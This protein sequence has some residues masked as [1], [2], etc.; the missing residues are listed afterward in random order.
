MRGLVS[1]AGRVAA[2]L[3]AAL[4]AMA[5]LAVVPSAA[6]QSGGLDVELPPNTDCRGAAVITKATVVEDA[7]AANMLAE[8]LSMLSPSGDER[9]LLDAGLPP[10][11]RDPSRRSVLPSAVHR[12]S[13]G[14][15]SQAYVVGG[16]AAIPDQW[17]ADEFGLSSFVRVAGA[18]RWVT[19]ENVAA[20]I[21]AL[22]N[23]TPVREYDPALPSPA[24]S[25]L[26]PNGDCN[27][28][29]VLAKLAIAEERA[30]ANMLAVAL[31]AVSGNPDSRCL[32]NVGDPR[33][34]IPPTAV[35]VTDAARA[36]GAYLL[37]GTTAVP[38]AWIEDGFDIRFLERIS[39]PDRWATQS[40]VA[41]TIIG[42]ARGHAL[43]HQYIDENGDLNTVFEDWVINS[44]AVSRG[45]PNAVYVGLPTKQSASVLVQY[46]ARASR[47]ATSTDRS[48][49]TNT[50]KELVD[51]LNEQ[52]SPFFRSQSSGHFSVRFD[53]GNHIA[54]SSSAVSETDWN[55]YF[56]AQGEPRKACTSMAPANSLVFVD[57][58]V[59]SL[60]GIAPEPLKVV[61]PTRDSFVRSF[62]ERFGDDEFLSVVAHEMGHAWLGLC[63]PHYTEDDAIREGLRCRLGHDEKAFS[64]ILRTDIIEQERGEALPFRPKLCSVMSY[65]GH[66]GAWYYGVQTPGPPWIA[67]GQREI[68]GWPEGPATPHGPCS[69]DGVP[70]DSTSGLGIVDKVRIEFEWDEQQEMPVAVAVWDSYDDGGTTVGSIKCGPKLTQVSD[71]RDVMARLR[72]REAGLARGNRESAWQRFGIA[73]RSGGVTASFVYEG[74]GE[75]RSDLPLKKGQKYYFAV[76]INCTDGAASSFSDEVMATT[77]EAWKPSQPSQPRVT[78]G[79]GQ[80]RVSWQEPDSNR[81]QITEYEI[82]FAAPPFITRIETSTSTS[83]TVPGLSNGTTYSIQIRALNSEG[84]SDWSPA[85]STTLPLPEPR[86]TGWHYVQPDL[87]GTSAYWFQG[88]SGSGY[89]SDNYRYTHA[90]GDSPTRDNWAVWNMGERVGVQE[91]QVFVPCWDS[92]ASVVYRVMFGG[93]DYQRRV[94]QRNECGQNAWTSLGRFDANGRNVTITLNDNEATPDHRTYPG[95]NSLISGIGVDDI[96]MRCVDRCR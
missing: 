54:I 27:S 86:Q 60:V 4:V 18:D 13:A 65:C 67:C 78:A 14:I 30:A 25:G 83:I 69:H 8:A 93:N 50:I 74:G 79:D 81:A 49:A 9:C 59:G 91:I 3:M 55:E 44:S 66:V 11:P 82:S 39:G 21:I 19:Q 34:H 85:A 47:L 45:D 94:N 90:Y 5:L 10:D 71:Q 61:V 43:P 75:V 46:C 15:A 6:A 70:S 56:S 16:P 31:T 72:H 17:L 57:Q 73:K 48:D 88:R 23:E 76:Q 41:R 52:V 35:A 84:W 7:A 92:V 38:E 64:E 80:L 68:L 87:R 95:L 89:G 24:T 22:A 53:S 1:D 62:G 36:P 63:H 26:P 51:I 42:I 58:W 32:V 2:A 33:A 12:T 29:A 40:E 28:T 77:P 20:A 96:R 37:G